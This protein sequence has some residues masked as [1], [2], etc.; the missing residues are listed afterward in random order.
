MQCVFSVKRAIGRR[1][2]DMVGNLH[3]LRP[4]GGLS[5]EDA[6]VRRIEKRI[7]ARLGDR[8]SDFS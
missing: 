8:L 5:R 2:R 6:G 3:L 1:R 7:Q 4:G